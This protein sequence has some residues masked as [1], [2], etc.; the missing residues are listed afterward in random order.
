MPV[1]FKLNNPMPQSIQEECIKCASI[2]D[3]FV[4]P[5]KAK[6][7]DQLIPATILANAKGVAIIT[8][9]KGGFLVTGKAGS[10]LVVVKLANG[11]WSAP[12]AICTAG[13]GFGAQ[14]GA[15]MTDVV[16]ILNNAEAIKAFSSANV[17]LGTSVSIAAGPIGRD[18][19]IGASLG[20]GVAAVY[21]Y[22]KSKGLFA[23]IALTGS[24]VME[25]KEAN[26]KFYG[27]PITADEILSGKVQQPSAA[28]VLYV[29]LDRRI[30]AAIA[31]SPTNTHAYNLP[32][33]A[34]PPVPRRP[35]QSVTAIA[36]YDYVGQVET[37]L[38]FLKGDYITVTKKPGLAADEWW[39]G[40]HVSSG[41]AGTFPSNHVSV[42]Q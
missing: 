7:V 37:D 4:K 32:P 11:S 20:K 41:K 22:S 34:A 15:E 14:I 5:E 24:A 13:L 6:A 40:I 21:S 12:S 29:A 27:R 10:G 1:D 8:I 18:A 26:A 31:S 30:Q 42:V 9:I 28:N 39:E 19:E 25:R 23:G 3:N 2:I 35:S 17:T 16:L 36:T 38:S 33:N